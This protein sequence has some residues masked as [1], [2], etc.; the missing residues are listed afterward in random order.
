MSNDLAE[1]RKIAAAAL[2]SHKGKVADA[3]PEIEALLR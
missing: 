1:L 2:R 3:A